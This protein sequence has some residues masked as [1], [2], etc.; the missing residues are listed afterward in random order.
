M[1]K[2]FYYLSLLLGL[3]FGMTMFT[4]CG[5]GDDDDSGNSN[6]QTS[7]GGS[8]TED[9]GT[10]GL[11]GYWVQNVWDEMICE[12]WS[13][14]QQEVYGEKSK[15]LSL[16]GEGGGTIYMTVTT[17]D[18]AANNA[19]YL[20]GKVGTFLDTSDGSTKDYHF[21]HTYMHWDPMYFPDPED[22]VVGNASYPI[23]YYL[24]GTT[25][26]IFYDNNTQSMQLNFSSGNVSGYHRL[27]KVD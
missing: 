24:Q 16:D 7:G 8:A 5:G 20:A 9:Y 3:V 11:K 10:D 12:N 25:M 6:G 21:T 4:A 19:K 23:T 27:K 26:S 18:H 14:T 13:T 17:L 15:L 22:D 2:T 1:K